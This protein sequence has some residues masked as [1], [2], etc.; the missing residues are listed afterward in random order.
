MHDADKASRIVSNLHCS[1]P[2]WN[3][4]EAVKFLSCSIVCLPVSMYDI[5]SFLHHVPTLPT[6]QSGSEIIEEL[7]SNS[8]T[9]DAKTEFSQDKYKR[10]KA[11][12]YIVTVTA[13]RPTARAICQVCLHVQGSNLS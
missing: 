13:R 12:K 9:F 3:S 1:C 2:S 10:K 6:P 8:A 7:C 11:K 5:F 4:V